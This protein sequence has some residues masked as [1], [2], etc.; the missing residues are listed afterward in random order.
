MP[1]PGKENGRKR[2]KR[3]TPRIRYDFPPAC[4]LQITPRRA[5]QREKRFKNTNRPECRRKRKVKTKK[6]K[7]LED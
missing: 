2:C 1:T 7:K 3:K 6:A 4:K 5:H